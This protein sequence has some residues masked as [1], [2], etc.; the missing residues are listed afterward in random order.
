M[1]ERF[2]A[3]FDS[4]EPSDALRRRVRTLPTRPK[5]HKPPMQLRI[6]TGVATAV[7]V[8]GFYLT[9][10]AR[11]SRERAL[12]D[13]ENLPTG[14]SFRS[15]SPIIP[16][17]SSPMRTAE[18]SWK[19]PEESKQA[20]HIYDFCRNP[21]GQVL[22]LIGT[23][24]TPQRGQP[25]WSNDW[26]LTLVGDKTALKPCL[27]LPFTRE[28][29]RRTKSGEYRQALCFPASEGLRLRVALHRRPADSFTDQKDE[30]RQ[31][32]PLVPGSWAALGVDVEAARALVA[33]LPTK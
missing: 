5:G 31:V 6:F 21:R 1:S 28:A 4:P 33:Q 30:A 15:E 3:C 11:L 9:N 12:L 19:T 16:M 20:L 17:L 32:E 2:K 24:H 22:L 27:D 10:L 18:A 13:F 7:I 23:T 8:G 26:E 29:S 25:T 14:F